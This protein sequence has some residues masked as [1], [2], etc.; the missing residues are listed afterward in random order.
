MFLPGLADE[1]Y[2]GDEKAANGHTNTDEDEKA[3]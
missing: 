1:P 2:D 3:P